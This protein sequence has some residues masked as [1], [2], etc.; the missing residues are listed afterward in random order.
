MSLFQRLEVK[1]NQLHEQLAIELQLKGSEL[2]YSFSR[3]TNTYTYN[4]GI[5]DAKTSKNW[6]EKFS[7]LP[8]SEWPFFAQGLTSNTNQENNHWNV[9]YTLTD[10]TVLEYGGG[11]PFP[12]NWPRFQELLEELIPAIVESYGEQIER[13]DFKMKNVDQVMPVSLI[14]SKQ[15][16]LIKE[17]TL[18]LVRT[19]K[20]II[21]EKIDEIN[22][23][24]Y[25]EF[26]REG[27]SYLLDGFQSV[28]SRHSD[29][30]IQEGKKVHDSD[31]YLKVVRRN[32]EIDEFYWDIHQMSFTPGWKEIVDA[33]YEMM[34][35]GSTFLGH[36]FNSLPYR[37][38]NIDSYILA[39]VE[40]EE[41]KE[42]S[43]FLLENILAH[44][45]DYLIVPVG[46][47]LEEKVARILS[48][49]YYTKETLPISLVKLRRVLRKVEDLQHAREWHREINLDH[50]R[51]EMILKKLSPEPTIDEVIQLVEA[52]RQKMNLGGELII[53]VRQFTKVKEH[54]EYHTTPKEEVLTTNDGENWEPFRLFVEKN[55]ETFVCFTSSEEFIK[56]GQVRGVVYPISAILELA[57][58]TPDIY[59]L[60]VNPWGKPFFLSKELIKLIFIR[61]QDTMKKSQ[62]YLEYADVIHLQ[63]DCIINNVKFST[64]EKDT[65]DYALRQ[66][67]GPALLP[68][69][70]QFVDLNPGEIMVSPGFGSNAKYIFHTL[71]PDYQLYSNAEEYVI[72]SYWEALNQARRLNLKLMILPIFGFGSAGFPRDKLIPLIVETIAQWMAENREYIL[73]V[74]L[75]TDNYDVYNDFHVYLENQEK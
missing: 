54:E 15:V 43:Y 8:L 68:Y 3:L 17:E 21:Y 16:Y 20:K 49:E 6:I 12:K 71:I 2:Y 25:Y 1:M 34:T 70:D 36:I 42:Q 60:L 48:I 30:D 28:F 44:Q 74:V 47:K 55:K 35:Q 18:S 19:G 27:V 9:V 32:G 26:E 64:T 72:N 63:A 39:W 22:Q 5:I 73:H 11:Y 10:G 61:N 51:I 14:T 58:K 31:V 38:T 66:L 41:T 23:K 59:G 50:R 45:G 57:L 75:S 52:I 24:T 53:P 56:D 7:L 65:I 40:I 29:E 67:S 33:I 4:N 62:I 13:I 69:Y 37:Y 46:N